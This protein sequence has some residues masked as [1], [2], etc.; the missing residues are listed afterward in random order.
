[1]P[2]SRVA[3]RWLYQLNIAAVSDTI[4][5]KHMLDNVMALRP[6]MALTADEMSA[7]TTDPEPPQVVSR[8]SMASGAILS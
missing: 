4:N 8:G 6:E 5:P 2:P 7:I 3:L 1:M